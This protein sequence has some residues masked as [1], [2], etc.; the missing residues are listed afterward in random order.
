MGIAMWHLHMVNRYRL[1]LS[2]LER[3]SSCLVTGSAAC[4]FQ[5]DQ[6]HTEVR[7]LRGVSLPSKQTDELG[8]DVILLCQSVLRLIS[9]DTT[10]LLQYESAHGK[11]QL[12]SVRTMAI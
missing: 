6:V 4:V 11:S 1:R 12:G 5:A 3:L 7:K 8:N 2:L 10:H 9:W